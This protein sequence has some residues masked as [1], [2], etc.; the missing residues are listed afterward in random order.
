MVEPS[1]LNVFIKIKHHFVKIN[2]QSLLPTDHICN[3]SPNRKLVKTTF[4][5]TTA[6]AC[7]S[8]I[9]QVVSAIPLA[10]IMQ[11]YWRISEFINAPDFHKHVKNVNNNIWCLPSVYLRNY[12]IT[13]YDNVIDMT[14]IMHTKWH[15]SVLIKVQLV[16]YIEIWNVSAYIDN[17][18]TLC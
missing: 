14:S 13:W 5:D 4:V 10:C 9:K 11:H 8:V 18:L 7:H 3:L 12:H 1:I 16:L 17:Y 2:L 6:W 15:Y